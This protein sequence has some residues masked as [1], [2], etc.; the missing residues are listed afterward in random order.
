MSALNP[1]AADRNLLFGILALQMDFI[2]KDALIAALHAWVLDKAKPLGQILAEQGQLTPDLRQLL[3]AMVDKHIQVHQGD[4]QQSLAAVSS[5]SS[6]RHELRQIADDDVQASLAQVSAAAASQAE[7]TASYHGKDADVPGRRYRILRPHA[8]GGLGEVFVA[9]DTEL[10]REVAL[11]EIRA[12]YASDK[13]S[14]GRFVLEAEVTGGL[15][16][17]GIV[18]VYG[19]GQYQDG[20]PFYAMRF[21]KGD[22]L[23]EAIQRF[24]QADTAQR[25]SGERNIAFRDLLGR[26]VDVCNA[27]AYAHSRGVLHRDLKPGK[28][29][30][31]RYGETLVVG[32]G[33][34]KVV[35][36]SETLPDTGEATLQPGS[37]DSDL[38]ATR[39]GTAV[40]TAAF[41]S[42]EQA[43]GR[44]DLLGPASDIYSLGATSTPC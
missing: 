39:M 42:P 34:A 17:P 26:F 22:N 37:A 40:G 29:M 23:K 35:G 13:H 1:G 28:V 20:R 31:G 10:H 9:E 32:W 7:G 27:V 5:A 44:L 43:A 8:R 24:H 15:E 21:V 6:V 25:G 33:L 38:V 14:R 4:P 12:E 2:R 18:P 3:E 41:M 11:K 19:L 36:R 30:L 16:H